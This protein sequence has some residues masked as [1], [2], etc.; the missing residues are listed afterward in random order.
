METQATTKA[1][2]QVW[3]KLKYK[4]EDQS[5]R[6]AHS[7]EKNPNCGQHRKLL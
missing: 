7:W 3:L 5:H 4:E 1:L 6:I 2:E